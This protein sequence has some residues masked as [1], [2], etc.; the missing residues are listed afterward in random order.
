MEL[1]S[2][3]NVTMDN[4]CSVDLSSKSA[5]EHVALLRPSDSP[6]WRERTPAWY[7]FFYLLIIIYSILFLCFAITCLVLLVKRHLAQRFKVRTFIAIDVTLVVL[8]CSRFL[9]LLIDPWGQLGFCTHFAC[10]VVSRLLGALGFPSLTASYTLVFLTLWISAKIHLGGSWVQ[11]LNMLIPLCCIH[12]VV[13]LIFEIILLVPLKNSTVVVSL[14]ISCEAVFSLW[15][16]IVCLLFFIA[17][18]RLLKTIEKTARSSSVICRDSPNLSRHDLIIK[19]AKNSPTNSPKTTRHE[20]I[21]KSRFQKRNVDDIRKRTASTMKLKHMLQSKQKRAL[22]KITLI[23]YVTVALGMLYSTLS[24]A[25]L[26]VVV[27]SL[28]DG[29]P[30]EI[31][32]MQMWP[33]LWLFLRYVLF[34]IEFSMALLLTYAVT[35]YM[36]LINAFKKVCCEKSISPEVENTRQTSASSVSSEPERGNVKYTHEV[37]EK[38]VSF[39]AQN[40]RYQASSIS[41]SVEETGAGFPADSTPKVQSPLVVSIAADDVFTSRSTPSDNSV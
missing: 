28:F 9:F 31:R 40:M 22:R 13:A 41:S 16:F 6:Y 4:N 37:K 8:G 36:P 19:P 33:E 15:G 18:F 35:D 5:L 32:G 34:T 23:T 1:V 30:G 12:Y 17:G 25:N 39:S 26:F 2:S 38:G 10:I 27:F 7:V 3:E 29:C 24:V 21:E 14:I 20:L 11:R